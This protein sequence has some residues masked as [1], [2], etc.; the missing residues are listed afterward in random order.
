MHVLAGLANEQ[1]L[2]EAFRAHRDHRRAA[3][4]VLHRADGA[5]RTADHMLR[6]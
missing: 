4:V 3:F 6:R 5:D 1:L 2:D